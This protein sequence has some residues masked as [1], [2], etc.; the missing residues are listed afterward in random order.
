MSVANALTYFVLYGGAL[1]AAVVITYTL[2]AI[3]LI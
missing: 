3:K 1:G 2:R